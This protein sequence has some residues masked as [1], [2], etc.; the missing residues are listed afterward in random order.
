MEKRSGFPNGFLWGASTS[1]AQVEGGFDCD[2]RGLSIWDVKAPN[3]GNCTFHYASDF[4]HH[5]KDD[6]AMMA[7]MGFKA[8]RMSISWSRIMP[9]GEGEINQKGIDFY[10]DVFRECHKFG[11]EPVVT[12]FHFDLP[13]ALK[14]KY[15]GWRS[16]KLI[17]LY[18]E[19]CRVLFENYKDDVKYWLT[20]N[21]QNMLIFFGAFDMIG[22]GKRFQTPN[23]LY[24][25][26][27][28]QLVAQAKAIQLCHEM[29][30]NAK[31]GPAPN[32]TTSYPKTCNPEDFIAAMNMDELR[33]YM[34][35]DALVYGEYPKSVY[36]YFELN[37]VELDVQEGDFECMKNC[38]PDFIGFNCYG[39]DTTEHLDFYELDLVEL[40]NADN[41]NMSYLVKLMEKPGVGKSVDNEY[42]TVAKTDG[43]KYD[44]YCIR[45]TARCLTDRYHLPVIITENGYG[46]ADV[47]E[48]DG[49]VHDDYRI[50]HLRETIQQMKLG[51]EEGADIFGYCPWSALDLVSTREGITK[52][53]GFIYVDRDE[54]DENAKDAEMKRYRKD[55]FY[56]YKKVIATNGEDLD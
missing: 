22:G 19:Y 24:N 29:C 26:A 53:Y 1:S 25:D 6:I 33:N 28:R 39:N 13:L 5:Y 17:D 36:K 56:W 27:H 18:V 46:R 34:Y 45:V 21:E 47:L 23:D 9:T 55:S 31:I 43:H 50:E 2:G 44:P 4:Y 35:L 40:A 51:I 7:E 15:D 3:S 10:K 30:P 32:I 38:H 14:E 49:S 54:D 37:H 16:R 41:R 11:I 12:I 8:Y 52:R 42:R 48:E 20:F